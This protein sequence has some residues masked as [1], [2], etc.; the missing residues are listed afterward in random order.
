LKKL[1]EELDV[2]SIKK[3]KQAIHGISRNSIRL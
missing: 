2:S 1:E 3:E